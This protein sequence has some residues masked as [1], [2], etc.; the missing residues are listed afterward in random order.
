M[1]FFILFII[2]NFL[3]RKKEKLIRSSTII[4]WFWWS[5]YLLNLSP[6][7]SILHILVWCSVAGHLTINILIFCAVT[8][9]VDEQY[10]R[11]NTQAGDW[12][13][14]SPYSCEDSKEKGLNLFYLFS[15]NSWLQSSFRSMAWTWLWIW[16]HVIL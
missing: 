1:A 13:R 14:G 4:L 2:Q 10:W 6:V 7:Q 5:F 3:V 12:F 9:N 8:W 15:T 16:R 11:S